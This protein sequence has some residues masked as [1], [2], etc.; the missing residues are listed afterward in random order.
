MC[1]RTMDSILLDLHF[2]YNIS[3]LNYF[4]EHSYWIWH[5]KYLACKILP[6]Q[7]HNLQLNKKNEEEVLSSDTITLHLLQ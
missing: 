7:V 3:K 4:M 6:P 1:V 2:Y 5:E